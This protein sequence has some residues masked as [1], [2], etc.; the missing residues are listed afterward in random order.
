M[1]PSVLALTLTYMYSLERCSAYFYAGRQP[2]PQED[3][4][5]SQPT[6]VQSDS[7]EDDLSLGELLQGT[8]NV[9]YE[10][11]VD[12]PGVRFDKNGQKK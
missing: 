2:S 9:L 5:L 8:Q 12:V 4:V 10:A 7:K 1:N 11:K 6:T 3:G